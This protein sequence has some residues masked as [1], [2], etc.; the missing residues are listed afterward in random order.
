[1]AME[2][3]LVQSLYEHYVRLRDGLGVHKT[4]AQYGAFPVDPYSHTPA[5]AGVQQPGMTGQVKEDVIS[6]FLEL[7][8]V[9]EQGEVIFDPVLLQRGEFLTGPETWVHWAGGREQQEVLAGGTLG[10]S[11]CGVPV[12]YR[13]AES[14]AIRL[15]D[16]S[17]EIRVMPGTRLGATC[18]RALFDRAG[19]LRRIEVDLPA[20][21]L[22]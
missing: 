21:A 15:L 22:R 11:L 7:G 20:A 16:G 9:V 8:V 2:P 10:F 6:R 1:L 12:I 17:G 3:G 13:Q 14:A 4:P 18:S 5:F 19:E